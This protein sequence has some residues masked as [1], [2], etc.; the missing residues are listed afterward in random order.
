LPHSALKPNQSELGRRAGAQRFDVDRERRE[1]AR[2][3]SDGK[4]AAMTR[5]YNLSIEQ[6]NERRDDALRERLEALRAQVEARRADDAA[7]AVV[8]EQRLPPS[9]ICMRHASRLTPACARAPPSHSN[10]PL[11]CPTQRM[12]AG[13]LWAA[14]NTAWSPFSAKDP[15]NSAFRTYSAFHSRSG[16]WR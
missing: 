15:L 16:W 6:Q 8:R 14:R 9:P 11:L 5:Q 1:A 13:G 12:H 10:R 4:L 3:E 7:R 2:H